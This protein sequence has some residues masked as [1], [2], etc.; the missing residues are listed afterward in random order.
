M[1]TM[2][3]SCAN[4]IAIGR[5]CGGRRSNSPLALMATPNSAVVSGCGCATPRDDEWRRGGAD[6]GAQVVER[7][8]PLAL[9]NPRYYGAALRPRAMVRGG[10]DVGAVGSA[11]RSVS[12]PTAVSPSRLFRASPPRT[13][14]LIFTT[15]D[16]KASNGGRTVTY[17]PS[18][19]SRNTRYVTGVKYSSGQSGGRMA[20][21]W[22]LP[23]AGY[24]FV[25]SDPFNMTRYP[26][27]S[28]SPLSPIKIPSGS[29]F[30][31]SLS[32]DPPVDTGGFSNYL[33]LDVTLVGW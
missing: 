12:P 13:S 10:A 33:D 17:T 5:S 23:T 20:T 26:L 6:V 18:F 21:P 8:S 27:S 16:G 14:S 7:G 11:L 30:M 2:N 22:R 15:N 28:A 24:L 31:I 1:S 19:P 9:M 4:C 29:R 3:A 25:G 32:F